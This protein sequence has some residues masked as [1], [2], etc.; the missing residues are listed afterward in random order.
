MTR[1]GIQSV[2]LAGLLA[3]CAGVGGVETSHRDGKLSSNGL[4][5]DLALLDQLSTAALATGDATLADAHAALLDGPRGRDFLS[6]VALC[7]LDEGQELSA[8]GERFA[9]LYGLAPQWAETECDES[10]QRWVSSCVLAHANAFGTPVTV[11]LRGEH[12]GFSWTEAHERDFDAQE[13]AFYGNVFASPPELLACAGQGIHF[14][15]TIYAERLCSVS[16]LC[17]VVFTGPCHALGSPQS[18]PGA[19]AGSSCLEDAG[20][21][22][23]FGDCKT[24]IGDIFFQGPLYDEVVTVY[25]AE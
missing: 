17:G 16:G 24:S 19:N 7:A 5:L 21:T 9:G 18:G 2:V 6:Y 12:P 23:Y 10:C 15:S 20:A 22:G 3:G 8:G 25:V 13:A 14:D 11:S 1:I 4:I